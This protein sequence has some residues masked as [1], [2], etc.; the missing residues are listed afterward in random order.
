VA[1]YAAQAERSGLLGSL[2]MVLS[3]LGTTLVCGVVLVEIAGASGVEVDTVLRAGDYAG[4]AA[5][6]VYVVGAAIT[7]AALAWLGV[8]L[9][10]TAN[11]AQRS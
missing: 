11:G 5:P 7:C 4:S 1:L 6:I 3:V 9:T 8:G 2:G 10:A